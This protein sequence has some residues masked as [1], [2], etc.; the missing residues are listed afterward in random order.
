[1]FTRT[2]T[3]P[4]SRLSSARN[5]IALIAMVL[6]VATACTTAENPVE[7]GILHSLTGTM[8][9]S[10]TS[11]RDVVQMAVDEINADGGRRIIEGASG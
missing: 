3:T 5:L 7:V 9:I 10:E 4:R 8:A 2:T 6:I 1:M 11:L